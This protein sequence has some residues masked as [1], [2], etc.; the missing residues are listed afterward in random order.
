M[1]TL[2]RVNEVDGIVCAC[3][4]VE[5][6]PKNGTDFQLEELQDYIG[7]YIEIVRLNGDEIMVIDE[8]GKL[9]NLPF[10]VGATLVFNERSGIMDDIIVGNALVC[11]TEEVR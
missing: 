4:T 8:E 6:Q 2:Y 11:K 7:G 1:A 9:K 10:N 3:D 5:V